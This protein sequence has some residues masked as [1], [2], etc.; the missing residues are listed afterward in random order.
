VQAQEKKPMEPDPTFLPISA[1]V[2]LPAEEISACQVW[3]SLTQDQQVRLL[4]AIVLICQEV[5][6]P[7]SQIQESEVTDD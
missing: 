1:P 3:M 6:W 5:I 2:A 7:A 4:Q